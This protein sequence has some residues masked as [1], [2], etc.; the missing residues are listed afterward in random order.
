MFSFEVPAAID[1]SSSD[2]VIR[3]SNGDSF[4]TSRD[5]LD[6]NGDNVTPSQLTSGRHIT[7]QRQGNDY[8]IISPITDGGGSELGGAGRRH[9]SR[10]QRPCTSISVGVPGPRPRTSEGTATVTVRSFPASST[11]GYTRTLTGTSAS[12]GTSVVTLNLS[13]EMEDGELIE[14]LWRASAGGRVYGVSTVS[15]DAILDLTA[16]TTE[17]GTNSAAIQFKIGDTA[18]GLSAFGH[19]SGFVWLIDSNSIYVANGRQRA[20]VAEVYELIPPAG[21]G[22]GPGSEGED[23]TVDPPLGGSFDETSISVPTGTWAYVNFG[24]IGTFRLGEWHRFLV[25]DLTG[26]TV[27]T[28]GGSAT[29]ATALT[30]LADEETYFFVGRTTGG[31]VLIGSSREELNPGT[32]RIRSN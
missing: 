16:Q 26:L 9:R 2:L 15:A 17:P 10:P 27:S 8:V 11:A 28:D 18:T 31:N 7:C 22:S 29:D 23:T 24:D 13:D 25:A 32:V 6:L 14:I 21:G 3:T 12:L 30:F 20:M 19:G 4:G 5:V 1:T